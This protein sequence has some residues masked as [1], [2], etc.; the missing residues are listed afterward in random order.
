MYNILLSG[1][2]LKMGTPTH[3]SVSLSALS[4]AFHLLQV[5]HRSSVS[6]PGSDYSNRYTTGGAAI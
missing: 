6:D 1:A 4:L 2:Q 3:S 5:N